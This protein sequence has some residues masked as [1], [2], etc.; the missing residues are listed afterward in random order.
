MGRRSN[1]HFSKEDIQMANKHVKRCS[2]SPIIKE[3]QIKTTMRLS[4]HTSQNG[5]HLKSLQIVN[6]GEGME[7]RGPSNTVGGNVNWCK[8]YGG[9]YG[10][11]LKN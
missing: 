8:H 7:K 1:G 11:S 6:V 5:H 9:Q 4:L 10:G 3:M 2:K